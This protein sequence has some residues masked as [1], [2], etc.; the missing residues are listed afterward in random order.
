MNEKAIQGLLSASPEKR[1]KS[2]LTTA[3]DQAE[4]W[5]LSSKD[6]YATFDDGGYIHLLIWAHREFAVLFQSAGGEPVSMEIHDFMEQCQSLD[7]HF[8]FMVF[9]T[10]KD[11]YVVTTKQLCEDLAACLEEVE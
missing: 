5:L 1:Y 7:E 9:P 2:F 10:Q 3:A 4:V 6:G 8:R 11:T